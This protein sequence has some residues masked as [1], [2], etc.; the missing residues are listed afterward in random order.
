MGWGRRSLCKLL[1]QL[2]RNLARNFAVLLMIFF[3]SCNRKEQVIWS[4]WEYFRIGAGITMGRKIDWSGNKRIIG[5]NHSGNWSL[6]EDGIQ[7][8]WSCAVISMSKA[9]ISLEKEWQLL[10]L[11]HLILI[12]STETLHP[13]AFCI[14]FSS[15]RA[16]SLIRPN[17]SEKSKP[18]SPFLHVRIRVLALKIKFCCK[19]AFQQIFLRRWSC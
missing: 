19:M 3:G 4:N 13:L 5:K 11:T 12:F 1:C 17:I 6:K 8:F 9:V 2:G 7:D 10:W 14:H 15:V 16:S 18:V